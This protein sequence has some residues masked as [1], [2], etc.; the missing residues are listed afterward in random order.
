MDAVPSW[1]VKLSLRYKLLWT[2]L[3]CLVLPS[4]ASVAVSGYFTGD[5][6]RRQAVENSRES[7]R[8]ATIFMENQLDDLLYIAN[9]IQFN[10]DISLAIRALG[11]PAAAEDPGSQLLFK[12]TINKQ[13][14]TLLNSLNGIYVTVL[15][16]NGNYVANYST[17]AFHPQSFFTEPWFGKLNSTSG[18][19]VLWVGTIPTYVPRSDKPYLL[20]VAKPLKSGASVH[21]YVIVSLET[22]TTQ[23][24]FHQFTSN[25][26]MLLVDLNGRILVDKEMSRVGEVFPHAGE[27]PADGEVTFYREQGKE[28]IMLAHRLSPE[29][30]LVS[31]TPYREAVRR[32]ETFRNTSLLI[33]LILTVLFMLVL[34][35]LIGQLTKPIA[36]LVNTVVRIESGQMA[37]RSNIRGEDEVG[38]L[39][40]VFDRMLDRIQ[41][42]IEE[43]RREQE[44]KRKAELA[45]L[46]AQINPHFLFN[47]LNSIRLKIMMKGDEENAELISS[48]SSLLRMTINRNNEF[49]TLHEEI[50]V[51]E[52]YIR[53]LN[54]RYG[55]S[56]RLRI[57]AAS[58]TL[59]CI[60]PRFMLQPL[61]ENAYLH[62]LRRKAGTIVIAAH[63]TEDDRLTISVA[64]S[65]TGI[66]RE[67]LQLL[68][69]HIYRGT[70][71]ST[72]E[73]TS[74]S[75][76]GIGIRNVYERLSIIYGERLDFEI[77]SEPGSG[78]RIRI[79]IPHREE[80][81]RGAS[82][83]F[84]DAGR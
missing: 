24:L 32:I 31:V 11:Q 50:E 60:V 75:L 1:W 18:Y 48:L 71:E 39:G 29:W 21:G 62:G 79:R 45:M 34:L 65:G 12:Q 10:E 46:Q 70:E 56:V 82:D 83:D 3:V 44:L 4:I 9:Y 7:F 14:D 43:N 63:R 37:E 13:L 28:Y 58:D 36:R 35:Y 19:N 53:L 15:I 78:T 26:S 72:G 73:A 51:I 8:V 81:E 17:M 55:D 38:R 20:T 16:P 80:E 2:I 40:Y 49:V 54:S 47:V 74:G 59:L 5:E 77:D 22:D 76:S 27:L 61:I 66:D 33:Q 41:Q 68:R 25:E 52:H 30:H 23:R 6:L 64:D 57:E 69:E 42:M 67:R 84:R